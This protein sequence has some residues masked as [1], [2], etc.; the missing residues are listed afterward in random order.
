[1]EVGNGSSETGQGLPATPS[2]SDQQGVASRL[3]QDSTDSNQVLQHVPEHTHTQTQ[4][5]TRVE[6]WQE[7]LQKHRCE[8]LWKKICCTD[9]D[10]HMNAAAW[11]PR[12]GKRSSVKSLK[13]TRKAW[14]IQR[15]WRHTQP[16]TPILV[17][18]CYISGAD[19]LLSHTND[20]TPQPLP[21]QW[22]Q[23]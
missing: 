13:S 16:G 22:Y 10:S 4:N 23:I 20:V 19:L 8:K 11:P 2:H 17:K 18:R 12:N 1:M 6:S 3:F 9:R 15:C 14:G 21:V 7:H 5:T